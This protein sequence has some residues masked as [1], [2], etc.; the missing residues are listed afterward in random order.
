MIWIEIV[1]LLACIAVGARIG[2]I[3][4]GTTA[5]IGLSIF[6]FL[7]GLP[8]GPPAA[9]IGMIIAVIT[10]LQ[11]WRP[12]AES[13]ISVVGSAALQG[14]IAHTSRSIRGT[15]SSRAIVTHTDR[16]GIRPGAT[17]LQFP[18]SFHQ[19]WNQQLPRHTSTVDRANRVRP[20]FR[21]Q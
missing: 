19:A 15:T 4:I 8:G 16:T 3:G 17:L 13:T 14:P 10:A 12:R 20:G 9:V 5:G 18:A 1:V 11:P 21:R 6:V 7:F 2:G